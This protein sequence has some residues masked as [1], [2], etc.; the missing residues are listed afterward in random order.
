ML[1]V[2]WICGGYGCGGMR[3]LYHK[4]VVDDTNAGVRVRKLYKDK[5]EG[6]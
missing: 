5:I 1:S 4:P 2:D 3:K 6:F